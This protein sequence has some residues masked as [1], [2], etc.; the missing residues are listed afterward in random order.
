MPPAV[1]VSSNAEA[2][3]PQNPFF[4]FGAELGVW[5]RLGDV[6][7]HAEDFFQP[8]QRSPNPEISWQ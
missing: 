8:V 5:L 3:K 7:E 6:S 2:P 4:I 1:R